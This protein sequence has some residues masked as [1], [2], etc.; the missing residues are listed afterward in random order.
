[1]P[2]DY[3]E[4]QKGRRRDWDKLKNPETRAEEE[5]A[6]REREIAETKKKLTA[7]QSR[8]KFRKA[9]QSDEAQQWVRTKR[10]ITKIAFITIAIITV[11][12]GTQGAFKLITRESRQT[13]MQELAHTVGGGNRYAAFNDPFQAWASW[14]S[15]W[16]RRDPQA[17]YNTYSKE[18]AE[19]ERGRLSERGYI[20][21]LQRQMRRNM[22]EH[23][24]EIAENFR[25]PEILHLP[26]NNPA[27][28]ELAVFRSQPAVYKN[29]ATQKP[30]QWVLAISW[31]NE[32]KQWR[33]A[34]IR[35]ADLWRDTWTNA[36]NLAVSRKPAD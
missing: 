36:S 11:I 14:R 10:E 18:M 24:R 20:L 21:E 29:I 23:V 28:G 35:N 31:D 8:R 25:N 27:P 5:R 12:L 2:L 3:D 15:A 33:V 26:D 9:A 13:R 30:Q 16:L 6:A 17:I 4:I 7:A 19:R 32:I 1:M 22:K 34:D